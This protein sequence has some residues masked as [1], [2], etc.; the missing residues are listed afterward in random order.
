MEKALL[1]ILEN[2]LKHAR[3]TGNSERE[4]CLDEIIRHV[5]A[6]QAVCMAV[7]GIGEG[8]PLARIH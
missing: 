2:E 4:Q 3:A 8:V 5:L 6:L 1:I 7:L